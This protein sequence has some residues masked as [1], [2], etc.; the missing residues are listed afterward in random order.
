M[1]IVI[2]T[3]I[4]IIIFYE[5]SRILVKLAG[6]SAC[7]DHHHL[8]YHDYEHHHDDHRLLG[9]V[10]TLHGSLQGCQPGEKAVGGSEKGPGFMS[11]F[12]HGHDDDDDHHI[13]DYDDCILD[14]CDTR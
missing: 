8:H 6:I 9:A 14:Y 7:H 1:I 4:I 11:R 3:V 10:Q 2:Q 13:G 12:Y 5:Q